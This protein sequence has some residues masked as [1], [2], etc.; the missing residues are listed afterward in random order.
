MTQ[1]LDTALPSSTVEF[2]VHFRNGKKGRRRLREGPTP[3]S[4]QVESGRIPRIS[5]LMAL[6]IRF[7]RLIREGVVQD[8][9]DLAR[10]GG[11]SRARITQIMG[12]LNLAPDIQ[13][14]ILFLPRVMTGRDAVTERRLRTVIVEPAWDIQRQVWAHARPGRVSKPR[15]CPTPQTDSPCAEEPTIGFDRLGQMAHTSGET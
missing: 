5:R 2:P 12:L 3:Q 15:G 1:V 4:P 13:E 9:S 14:K 11:V 7:E 8:Y 10:L 6:A